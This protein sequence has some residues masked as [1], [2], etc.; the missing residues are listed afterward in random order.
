MTIENETISG[1]PFT[2]L[3]NTTRPITSAQTR[4][5]SRNASTAAI[6][7][8]ARAIHSFRRSSTLALTA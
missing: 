8:S 5:H 4:K 3:L 6:V 2:G 7:S 1:V